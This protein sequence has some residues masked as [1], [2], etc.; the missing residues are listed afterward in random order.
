MKSPKKLLAIIIICTA[1]ILAADSA[2]RLFYQ[3]YIVST[4]QYMDTNVSMIAHSLRIKPEVKKWIKQDFKHLIKDTSAFFNIY[5]PKSDISKINKNFAE[6]PFV[7]NSD[8]FTV[9]NKA[10]YFSEITNGY[11]D[12]TVGA[13]VKLWKKAGKENKLP[14]DE[15]IYKALDQCGWQKIELNPDTYVIKT[16]KKGISVNPSGIA[17]G[18][19]VDKA[20][21]MLKSTFGLNNVVVN[22]GGDLYAAGSSFRRFFWQKKGWTV[23]IKHPRKPHLI[24]GTILVSDK[25]VATSGDYERPL[26]I[27][28][29][30]YSHIIDPKTGSPTDFIVSATVIADSCAD[31]D[32]LATAITV[33]GIDDG[34]SL[35]ESLEGTEAL[36]ITETEG[37]TELFFSSGFKNYSFRENKSNII[38]KH[39]S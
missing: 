18:Y 29:K 19:I 8:L 31:A 36:V 6:T 21:K 7:L 3:E 30:N 1:C 2:R 15:E 26:T 13:L 12:I 16:D 9:I 23:G 37:Q 24:L 14:S 32:A 33:M 4:S 10:F 20:V 5:N 39:F 11:F 22:A 38:E 17:K 27:D 25:A 34:L 35:I 28:G